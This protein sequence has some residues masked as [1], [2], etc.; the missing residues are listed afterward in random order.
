MIVNSMIVFGND[1][2][3]ENLA[4]KLGARFARIEQRVFPDGEACPRIANEINDNHAIVAVRMSLPLDP[5]RHLIEI[6]LTIKNLKSLGVKKID[7]V[8]PYFVY[9]RQDKLFRKG[10]PLSAKY[11]LEMIKDAGAGRFFTVTS[12]AERNKESVSLSDSVYNIDGFVA[13]GD[14]L[15]KNKLENPLIIAPDDGA[16]EFA[17]TV[18]IQVGCEYAVF[19][20]HRDL[21][22]GSVSMKSGADIKGKDVIIV[23]DIISSG[24]TMLKAIGICKTNGAKSVMCAVVHA[25]SDKGI[26][27]NEPLI[28]TN[29]I[30]SKTSKISVVELVANMIKSLA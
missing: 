20:K 30:D 5:N 25:V 15:K 28:S 14:Y 10:E 11:V 13:V 9:A 1:N 22:T 24:S 18:A 12:H 26:D 7:V 27:N 19:E 16:E 4:E 29:T 6:L 3:G 17:E 2:F 8:M 23:D 21:D